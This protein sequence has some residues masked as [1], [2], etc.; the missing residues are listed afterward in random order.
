MISTSQS[1]AGEKFGQQL[2]LKKGCG[3]VDDHMTLIMPTMPTARVA[4]GSDCACSFSALRLHFA[5][6]G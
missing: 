4:R 1:L 3:K 6:H 2:W 5:R